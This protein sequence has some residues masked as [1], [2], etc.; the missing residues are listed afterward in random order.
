MDKFYQGSCYGAKLYVVHLIIFTYTCFHACKHS[1]LFKPAVWNLCLPLLE[2][3]LIKHCPNT[4]DA[5]SS[6]MLP[7]A[8]D[9]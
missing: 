8:G 5:I 9:A 2:V 7:D 3:R 1:T 4:F 6:N